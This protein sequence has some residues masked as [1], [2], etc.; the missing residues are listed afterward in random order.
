MIDKRI[1]I[2]E[3]YL[4]VRDWA[5]YRTLYQLP[6]IYPCNGCRVMEH[7]EKCRENKLFCLP[8][9]ALCGFHALQLA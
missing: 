8:L 6:G 9:S 2:V 3:L 5:T 1:T 4:R 7:G